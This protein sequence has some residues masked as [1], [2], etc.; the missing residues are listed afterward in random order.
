MVV[1]QIS[2][3]PRIA[4]SACL[5]GERVR[6]DGGHKMQTELVADLGP[7]VEWLPI[8]PEE[9]AGF[10]TPR[11]P[12]HLERDGAKL[13]LWTNETHEERTAALE[14]YAR[15][16]VARLAERRIAACILKARS[17]SCGVR[18]TV[19]RDT[20]SS[21]SGGDTERGA[22]LFARMLIAAMPGLPVVDEEELQDAA[23]RA[24]LRRRAAAHHARR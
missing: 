13:R 12:M 24:E 3:P 20:L 5:L 4:I 17:P 21:N 16:E 7:R 14:T 1:D 19:I 22:G 2:H 10:G 18:D 6:Y 11:E 9:G 8:C 23:A 15:A